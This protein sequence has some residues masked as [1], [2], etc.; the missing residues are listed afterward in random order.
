M[1]QLRAAAAAL[2]LPI[3]ATSVGGPTGWRWATGL[4]GVMAAAYGLVYLRLVEDTPA[5]VRLRPGPEGGGARGHEP[6]GGVRAAR[7]VGPARRCPRRHRLAHLVRRGH[8]DR[9]RSSWPSPASLALLAMQVT[10]V[11]RVNRPA[12]RNEVP[13]D[14]QYPFRSVAV[15]S[16]A[17]MCTFGSE[18]AAVSFLPEFFETHLGAVDRGGRSGGLG[19]RGDEPGVPARRRAPVRRVPQP[20]AVA[21]HAA[22]RAGR[23]LPRRLSTSARPGPSALA[24][25]TVLGIVALRPGRQRR[26]VRH[27][28]PGEEAGERADRR[29]RGA[30]GNVGGVLFLASL[31]FWSPQVVFAIMGVASLVVFAPRP[32]AGRAGPS[33]AADVPRPAPGDEP[34]TGTVPADL[35]LA[36][37][38]A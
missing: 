38:P 8:L 21:G 15:L 11:L 7:H 30:Y 27:R 24:I 9:R 12:L 5:G 34:T 1:G 19:L 25:G 16:L 29:A 37:S 35:A 17:Y 10:A 31:L 36:S 28:A 26:R 2:T 4:T 6:P 14:E 22:R 13:A 3:V 33:H 18:L 32:V 23:R 20:R